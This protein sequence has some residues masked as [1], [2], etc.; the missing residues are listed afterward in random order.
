M[1]RTGTMR[2]NALRPGYC[3]AVYVGAKSTYCCSHHFGWLPDRIWAYDTA[4]FAPRPC[5]SVIRPRRGWRI[6][7]LSRLILLDRQR[8]GTQ[9]VTL[10]RRHV[11][12]N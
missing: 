10:W 1:C 11:Y 5:E 7:V 2:R 8:V 12:C 4:V 3:G 6:S 9:H